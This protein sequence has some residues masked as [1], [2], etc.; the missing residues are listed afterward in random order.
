MSDSAEQ[1]GLVVTEAV[2]ADPTAVEGSGGDAKPK[3]SAKNYV[4]LAAY[5]AN[6][7]LVYGIGNAGWLGTP[8]NG[9]LS[10]KYQTLVTPNS[11]AFTIWA[12]IFMFQALFAVVQFLPRFRAHPMVVDGVSWWYNAV[13]L[14]QIGWTISFA[15]E[16][17][18]L[19]LAF[20]LLIWLSLMTILYRQYYAKS[21]GT[22]LE[23]WLLRF[24]FAIHA[25]WITAASALNV[26]VQVVYMGEPAYVQLSVAI[27]SLAVLHAV[28]VWVL[29]NIPRPNWTVACVLAWA[30]GW[31]YNELSDPLALITE[32]FS[33]DTIL[34]VQNA[35]IAVVVVICSQMVVRLGMLFLPSWNGYRKVECDNDSATHEEEPMKEADV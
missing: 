7:A 35:A 9:E 24:P 15:Y 10:D 34:G 17:V 2:P 22:L 19:S 25:G 5:A 30:F 6:I 27:V 1:S 31:I 16:V 11:S 14:M 13:V 29:F 26:N 21:D 4:N 12:V 23:F 32:T 8:T 20:M 18:P 28:S 3:L 33:T